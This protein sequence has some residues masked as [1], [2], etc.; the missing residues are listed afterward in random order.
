MASLN[1]PATL[2]QSVDFATNYASGSIVVTDGGATLATFTATSFASSNTGA[3]GTSTASMANAGAETI[4][5][6]GTA[7]GATMTVGTRVIT[8]TI[9]LAGSGADLII[10]NLTF[11][12][13]ETSTVNSLIIT[14]PA[15]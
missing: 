10:S 3:N 7:D 4:T 2:Q 9:G 12:V 1:A 15:S 13:G 11:V 6:A 5:G 8:L 14:H